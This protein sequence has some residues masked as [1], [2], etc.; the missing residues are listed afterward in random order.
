[1]ELI[2]IW[3]PLPIV[4]TNLFDALIPEDY[5]FDAA[6]AYHNRICEINFINLTSSQLERLASA[7]AIH[8]QFPAL[9]D[10][11]LQYDGLGPAPV[12][13]DGFLSGPV[14]HLQTLELD[15]IAF[16]GLP[17][18]LLS[19]TH[20][21]SLTLFNI[22]DSGYFSPETMVTNLAMLTNL[23]SLIIEFVSPLSRLDPGNRR[24]PPTTRTVLPA[25]TRFQFQGISEFLEDVV[26]R[27]D[28]PLLDSI[29]ITF[30]NQLRSDIPQLAQFMRRMTRFPTLNETHVDFYFDLDFFYCGVQVGSLPPTRTLDDKSKLRFICEESGGLLSSLAQVCT[31]FFPSIY[32]VEHLYFHDLPPPWHYD[33][34]NNMPWLEILH[35]FTAVKNLYLS[36]EFARFFAPALQDLVGERVIEMLPALESL[37]LED[38]Q[39]SGPV[40]EAIEQFVAARQLSGHPVAVSRWKRAF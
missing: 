21:V 4:I 18:L 7:M 13:P 30:F 32:M 35:P 5:D 10:L 33:A 12:L 8:V 40:Q 27:I 25:L 36:R 14:P 17:K 28:V 20:L 31:S 16:P 9:I 6:I 29:W 19:A 15:C 24:T 26:A 3:P 22:P 38:P 37:S 23:K 1:M 39:P 2:S 34:E 11:R